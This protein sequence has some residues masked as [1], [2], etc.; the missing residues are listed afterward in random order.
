MDVDI[1]LGAE[2]RHVDHDDVGGRDQ[3]HA[4]QHHADQPGDAQ[5][6]PDRNDLHFAQASGLSGPGRIA[7]ETANVSAAMAAPMMNS[8]C[9]GGTDAAPPSQPTIY[10]PV[11]WPM[12]PATM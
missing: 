1:P 7:S 10:G 5:D 9:V 3:D 11:P 12:A 6:L 2:Q 8:S 4:G